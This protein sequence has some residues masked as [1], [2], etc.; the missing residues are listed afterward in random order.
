MVG[1]LVVSG[2]KTALGRGSVFGGRHDWLR[3]ARW[4][5]V[6]EAKIIAVEVG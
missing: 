4:A 6:G 5:I 1:T 3:N 2:G